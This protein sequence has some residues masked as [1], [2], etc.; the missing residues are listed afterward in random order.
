MVGLER[1]SD[2]AI[3]TVSAVLNGNDRRPTPVDA[4]LTTQ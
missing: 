3:G 4:S 1:V 2:G